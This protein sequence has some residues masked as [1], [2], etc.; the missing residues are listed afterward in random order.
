[1]PTHETDP[2]TAACAAFW[3]AVSERLPAL[4]ALPARELMEAL[5]E[6]LQPL[7]PELAVEVAGEPPAFKLVLTAHGATAHFEDVMALARSSPKLAGVEVEA[8]R[9]RAT[10]GFGMRMN[11]F[12]LASADLRVR[13]EPCDGLVALEIAF[14]KPIPMDMQDH[15]RHMS[16]IMLDHVLGEYDF[17]VKVGPVDFVDAADEAAF[18]GVP[19]DDFAP[20]F[21]AC[22]RDELGHTGIFPTGEHAWSGLEA[23]REAEDG[24]EIEAMVMRNDSANALLGR[25]D[26]GHR[27]SA[28]VPVASGEELAQARSYEDRLSALLQTH[29]AGCCTHV[30]LEEGVRTVSYQVA[31]A[32]AAITHAQALQEEM[33]LPVTLA[34]AFDPGWASYRAWLD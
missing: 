3:N 21:D 20:A 9:Q 11:D 22:W 34:L 19:L 24:R 7:F 8:F 16:F 4:Q 29:E 27:L 28:A 1:M 14:A 25:A 26:L 13:Q 15:A 2:R 6:L 12:E 18:D 5:N 30:V 17:A 23:T 33:D 32:A 31:D 10:E